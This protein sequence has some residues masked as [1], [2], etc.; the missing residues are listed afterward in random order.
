MQAT[1]IIGFEGIQAIVPPSR[2]GW[3]ATTRVAS[4]P[5]A[6]PCR[7]RLLQFFGL[8]DELARAELDS[9]ILNPEGEQFQSLHDW[10]SE[11]GGQGPPWPDRDPGHDPRLPN[12]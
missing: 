6:A 4:P 1:S 8:A 9:A 11:A 7:R 5:R 2:V 3:V 12:V 10:L